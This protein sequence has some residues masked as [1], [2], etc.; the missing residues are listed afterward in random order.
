MQPSLFNPNLVVLSFSYE[1]KESEKEEGEK[2]YNKYAII[3]I[4]AVFFLAIAAIAV[5][6]KLSY[7][8]LRTE[9]MKRLCSIS[10]V[11]GVTLFSIDVIALFF[12]MRKN[13]VDHISQ[14]KKGQIYAKD[15][16]KFLTPG[17]TYHSKKTGLYYFHDPQNNMICFNSPEFDHD[18]NEYKVNEPLTDANLIFLFRSH[19]MI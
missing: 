1:A 15:L 13:E 5:H 12:M 6:I 7:S 9:A 3:G 16:I 17:D 2:S 10:L 8:D 19:H 11:G 18:P 4:V 14:Q